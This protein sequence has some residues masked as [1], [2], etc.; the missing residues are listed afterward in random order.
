MTREADFAALKVLRWCRRPA[1][2]SHVAQTGPASWFEAALLTMRV[3]HLAARAVPR[4]EA[5]A[6]G[7]RRKDG[8]ER[9][10]RPTHAALIITRSSSGPNCSRNLGVAGIATGPMPPGRNSWYRRWAAVGDPGAAAPPAPARGRLA[11]SDRARHRLRLRLGR[12]H[13]T[14][15]RARLCGKDRCGG[16]NHDDGREQR[17]AFKRWIDHRPASQSVDDPVTYPLGRATFR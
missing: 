1:G 7:E 9:E 4:P 10:L 3:C 8:R 16:R 5:L 17:A 12:R 11:F 13:D 14:T 15:S 6:G 2:L